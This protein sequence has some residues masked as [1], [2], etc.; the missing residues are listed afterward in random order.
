MATYPTL[1]ISSQSKRITRDGREEDIVGDGKI[2]VRKLH[3]D[4]YDFEIHHPQ[5]T[6]AQR[7]TLSTFYTTNLIIPFDFVWPADGVTY[8]VRFGKGGLRYAWKSAAYS[9]VFV[10]FVAA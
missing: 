4:R 6:S 2:R 8:S 3:D 10:R 1:P 9:D 7:S 5:L